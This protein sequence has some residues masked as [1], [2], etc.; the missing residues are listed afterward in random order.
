MAT[1]SLGGWPFCCVACVRTGGGHHDSMCVTMPA[2]EIGAV[3]LVPSLSPAPAPDPPIPAISPAR[4]PPAANLEGSVDVSLATANSNASR[5]RWFGAAPHSVG[6]YC[7]QSSPARPSRDDC[8]QG[9]VE[10]TVDMENVPCAQGQ[11]PGVP[12]QALAE[13]EPYIA[14]PLAP[15]PGK[16]S[17]RAGPGVGRSGASLGRIGT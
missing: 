12:A 11:E 10:D 14:S 1:Q 4:P 5:F 7:I 8:G 17:M 3:H 13:S 2:A 15:A 16:C 9:R 6:A